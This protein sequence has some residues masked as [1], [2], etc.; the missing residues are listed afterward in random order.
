[1]PR[2][3]P[4]LVPCDVEIQKYFE[5]IEKPHDWFGVSGVPHHLMLESELAA[6]RRRH[7]APGAA[8]RA[9]CAMWSRSTFGLRVMDSAVLSV[10]LPAT[11]RRARSWSSVCIPCA[12]PA[13]TKP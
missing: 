13:S 11:Q 8:S 4:A 5:A 7:L 6:G 10:I 3:W 9:K 1:M 12:P 2:M